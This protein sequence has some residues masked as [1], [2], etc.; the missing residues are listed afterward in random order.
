MRGVIQAQ[1]LLI[2]EDF[3]R[4]AGKF[5]FSF[6]L[7]AHA[8]ACKC[9]QRTSRTRVGR[10]LSI[11]N[12]KRNSCPAAGGWQGRRVKNNAFFYLRFEIEWKTTDARA[13][14][15]LTAKLSSYTELDSRQTSV[16]TF[17]D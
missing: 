5:F 13:W 8:S 4:L 10:P 2:P 9:M 3:S 6:F 12:K 16:L 17:R 14:E 1:N 11:I 15:I 7:Y